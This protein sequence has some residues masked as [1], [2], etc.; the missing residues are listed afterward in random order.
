MRCPWP[1]FSLLILLPSFKSQA[2]EAATHPNAEATLV[3]VR[4]APISATDISV[5][6]LG[7]IYVLTPDNQL[8]KFAPSGDSV[9]AYNDVKRF[10]TLSSTDVTNPLKILLFYQDFMTVVALDRFLSKLFTIDLRQAQIFQAS[11]VALAYDNNFWVYDE[12]NAQLKKIGDQGQAVMASNDLRQLFGEA[13]TPA[14]IVDQ[15]GLVYL[16]DPARGIYIFDYYGGFKVKLSFTGVR[17]LKVFGKNIFGIRDN[18]LFS[19]RPGTL[20]EQHLALPF[21]VKEAERIQIVAGGLYVLRG[22]ML[23]YYQIK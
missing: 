2:Q 10:G 15:D 11:A 13:V 21:P 5:D 20:Q 22:G 18:E 23:N 1:I 6:N 4:S 12:Q 16:N 3:L 19:Y 9:A 17:G 7:N 8:K 14:E